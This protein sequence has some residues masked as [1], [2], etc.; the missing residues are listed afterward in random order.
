MDTLLRLTLCCAA[1][2]VAFPTRATS[3]TSVPHDTPVSPQC[4][5][6]EYRQ[7]DFWLGEWD[8]HETTAPQ[9]PA[10][11][12]A[13]VTSVAQGCAIYERYEQSDG[14]IGESLLSYDP[15]REAWQQT[16][17]TNRG[18][19]MALVGTLANGTLMLE[20]DVHLRDGNTVTQR[21]GWQQQ[22][23]AVREFASLSK[24]G[25]ATWAPAFDVLF[26]KRADAPR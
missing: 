9:G 11:G 17:I 5:G 23:E 4:S 1:I 6:A 20:G 10:V 15:V 3:T 19:F 13:S 25:G 14:L 8:V 7:L 22:G 16:W 2:A 18:S 21:I 26:V 12:R 24:D